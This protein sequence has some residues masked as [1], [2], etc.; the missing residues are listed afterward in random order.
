MHPT[1]PMN[2]DLKKFTRSIALTA[3][4]MLT[5]ACA[6]NEIR[7]VRN[8]SSAA[9]EGTRL[10][11]FSVANSDTLPVRYLQLLVS[12][13][14]R[15]AQTAQAIYVNHS[16]GERLYLFSVP[17]QGFRFGRIRFDFLGSW[18]ETELPGPEIS[19]APG[20]VTYLG[21]LHPYSIRLQRYA[22]SEHKY[23]DSVNIRFRDA[24]DRDLPRLF[25][26]FRLSANIPVTEAIPAAW[27]DSEF[28][29]LRYLPIPG[30]SDEMFDRIGGSGPVGPVIPLG[31]TNP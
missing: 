5:G 1:P 29:R 9:D 10:V 15:K 22:N 7:P 21:Q 17:E 18:W 6:V 25:G 14:E 31:R 4:V 26:E 30:H 19:V 2:L 11:A 16:R 13:G 8:A 12:D 23:P 24:G 28:T 20:Q 3:V 27:S